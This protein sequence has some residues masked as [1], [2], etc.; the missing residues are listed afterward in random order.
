MRLES[1]TY[2]TSAEITSRGRFQTKHTLYP[3]LNQ[4]EM[5]NGERSGRP[6]FSL[7][8][9][10]I[11]RTA[12]ELA[13]CHVNWA[14]RTITVTINVGRRGLC[15]K[16]VSRFRSKKFALSTLNANLA[17]A[18]KWWQQATDYRW[19]RDCCQAACRRCVLHSLQQVSSRAHGTRSTR[20]VT[21]IPT[22]Y[23][24]CSNNH[25]RNGLG[26]MSKL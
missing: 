24:P 14:T 12:R 26:R 22:C 9:P 2:S 23:I 21:V 3:P 8:I 16:L 15:I 7:Q 1:K 13:A 6:Q 4:A 18:A 25:Q 10:L 19:Q 17:L 11:A 20:K 5:K